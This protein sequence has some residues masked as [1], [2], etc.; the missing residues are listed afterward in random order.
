M[1]IDLMSDQQVHVALL[2]AMGWKHKSMQHDRASAAGPGELWLVDYWNPNG[3]WMGTEPP[4]LDYNLIHEAEVK[5]LTSSDLWFSYQLEYQ[6]ITSK[7]SFRDIRSTSPVN[8]A[9]ALLKAVRTE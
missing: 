2:E 9:R 6:I 3:E 7:R 1:N 4:P 5:L 8:L